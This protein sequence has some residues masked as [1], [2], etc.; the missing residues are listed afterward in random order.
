MLS[1]NDEIKLLIH[2][3]TEELI[4]EYKYNNEILNYE[5]INRLKK[6]IKFL[7]SYIF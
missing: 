7:K 2:L 1:F 3:L 6:H 5:K 4:N